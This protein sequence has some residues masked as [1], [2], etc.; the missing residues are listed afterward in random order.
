M[1]TISPV[2]AACRQ[3]PWS[4]SYWDSSTSRASWPV[5]TT[6]VGMSLTSRDTEAS[7]FPGRT[8]L[9]RSATVCKR[10]SIDSSRRDSRP[11]RSSASVAFTGCGTWL[12]ATARPPVWCTGAVDLGRGS[13]IWGPVLARYADERRTD[14]AG[15]PAPTGS[16][17]ATGSPWAIRP[18]EGSDDAE[19][20]VELVE[21]FVAARPGR[22]LVVPARPGRR[23]D[24]GLD[25]R[26]RRRL[27]GAHRLGRARAQT[28]QHQMRTGRIGLVEVR[29]GTRENGGVGLPA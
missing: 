24:P 5:E 27:R 15:P 3:G 20:R 10:L 16:L 14:G 9:A 8:D 18:A 23:L 2:R 13:P 4:R 1:T 26:G 11:R 19:V 29:G 21:P 22:G 28:G 12:L 6:V 7:A 25:G 17:R